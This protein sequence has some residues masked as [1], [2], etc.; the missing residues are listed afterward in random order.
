M[1][2]HSTKAVGDVPIILQLVCISASFV[3]LLTA[4]FLAV[5]RF[6]S[7]DSQP[8]VESIT[9]QMVEEFGGSPAEVKIGFLIQSYPIFD[10]IQGKVEVVG[11]LFF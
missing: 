4:L 6:A 8:K 3:I 11:V 7:I 2:R 9:P 5:N 1:A 10:L